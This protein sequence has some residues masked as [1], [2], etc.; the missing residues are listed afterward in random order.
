MEKS[1]KIL[2]FFLIISSNIYGMINFDPNNC[3]KDKLAVAAF[4]LL[5]C[6]RDEE[7]RNQSL[8][9]NSSDLNEFC[10]E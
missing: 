9:L 5:V 10:G 6:Y 8:P 1:M 7:I 2:A 3:K 4:N